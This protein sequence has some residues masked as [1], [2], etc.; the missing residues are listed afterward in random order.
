MSVFRNL[1]DRISEWR[2]KREIELWDLRLR[3]AAGNNA[4]TM[5]QIDLLTRTVPNRAMDVE[6]FLQ[7]INELAFDPGYTEDAYRA[8][9]RVMHVDFPDVI[10][11]PDF[12]K[13]I[14]TLAKAG[15]DEYVL[16]LVD[17]YR[18]IKGNDAVLLN[19]DMMAALAIAS[20]YDEKGDVYGLVST[21]ALNAP[22]AA[23][24]SRGFGRVMKVQSE[25]YGATEPID[26]VVI[27]PLPTCEEFASRIPLKPRT[28]IVNLPMSYDEAGQ[29]ST[30][31]EH[32]NALKRAF[33]P[34]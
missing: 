17:F 26:R 28:G 1:A 12:A 24:R 2:V 31:V 16:D 21:L 13:I 27:S 4:S 14:Y 6:N 23:R 32:A 34:R 30:P 25:L 29:F 10:D 22:D 5:R 3:E 20:Q 33:G 15:Q 19:D 18:H 8:L 9:L 7:K 11:S